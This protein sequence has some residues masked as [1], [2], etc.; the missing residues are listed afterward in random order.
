VPDEEEFLSSSLVNSAHEVI[1][2]EEE[3]E[4]DI[5]APQSIEKD[6]APFKGKGKG[7]KVVSHASSQ[8]S[9]RFYT[10][11][12]VQRI[13]APA[14]TVV[15]SPTATPS[16]PVLNHVA[17]P[18]QSGTTIPLVPRRRKVLA[19]DTSANSS[20]RP[21]ILLLIENVDMEELIEDLMKTKVPPPAYH[22][23]QDFLTKVCISFSCFIHY[24]H[25]SPHLIVYFD[26][27]S[28]LVF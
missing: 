28:I 4:E 16:A 19:P 15:G 2:L 12:S 20:E 7:R 27:P 6:V 11:A 21:S 1:E 10:K 3:P 13:V 24:F 25:A 9:T 17:A 14:T 26:F 5:P 23:I 8:V 22:R 18:S